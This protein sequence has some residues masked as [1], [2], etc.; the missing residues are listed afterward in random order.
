MNL[1]FKWEERKP[2]ESLKRKGKTIYLKDILLTIKVKI[3]WF[4]IGL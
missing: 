3:L 2:K 4:I 1:S